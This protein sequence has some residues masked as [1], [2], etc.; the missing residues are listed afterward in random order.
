MTKPKAVL[1][2]MDGT[3]LD[4]LDDLTSA[5]NRTMRLYAY[6][7]HTRDEVRQFVGNGVNRL[8]ELALPGGAGDPNFAEAVADYRIW[9]NAHAEIETKPY[10]GI[11]ELL[12][13]LELEGIASAVVSNK[14]DAATKKLT[15]RFFPAVKISVGENEAAGILRKPAPDMVFEALSQMGVSVS[16]CVY[17]GDSE[18][19]LRTAEAAGCR[20]VSVLWGFR[21]RE[22]LAAEGARV[23][24]PTPADLFFLL[25]GKQL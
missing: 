13:A 1:F 2:D 24:A 9:Y 23:F 6:P 20:V 8:F 19:D 22:Q 10:P 5:V 18:V 21:S 25:T 14:P 4:T 15:E 16:D 12:E 3:L 17:V 11:P 7:E